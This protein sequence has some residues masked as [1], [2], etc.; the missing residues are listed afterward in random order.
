MR[1]FMMGLLILTLSINSFA[2]DWTQNAEL[3]GNEK[4]FDSHGHLVCLK[5]GNRKNIF[6]LDKQEL[7]EM[8][9][10]GSAHALNYPVAATELKIPV[11][12]ME[13]FFNADDRSPLRRFIFR[14]AKN[15]SP[16]KSFEDLFNWV[17]LHQYP[18][19]AREYGPN[20]IA[21]M[22]DLEKYPMGVSLFN[23]A[24]SESMTFS[25]AAC[26]SNNLF[27]TK[28]LGLTNRFPR[29]N[30]FFIIG[31]KVLRA[32]NALLFKTL[33]NPSKQDLENYKIARKAIKYV[34]L[35]KPLTL[36]LDT[37]LAQVGL[38]LALRNKDEQ[39]TRPRR[40]HNKAHP[41]KTNPADSKPAVWWNVKYKTKWLSDAS[42]D[43][44]NPIHTN[45]L[46]N[47]IGRGIDLQ[48]LD[49]WLANN[50]KKVQELTS[51]VFNTEAP[52]FNDYFPN[53]IDITRAKKGEKL[54]LKNCKGC[55][56]IYEKAWH[57]ESLSYQEQLATTKVWYHKKTIHVDVGTD[58]YRYLG[59]NSFYKDLNRL[60][61]SQNLGTVVSPKKGY[62]PPPLVGIWARWPYLHN[63][64]IPTLYDLLSAENN[65]PKFYIAT[66]SEDKQLDFDLEKNGYPRPE[67]IKEPYQSD[68]RYR[69]NTKIKGLSNRGHNKMLINEDG[70]EK[71]SHQD[72]LDLIHFLRSL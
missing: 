2:V 42:I 10:R 28:V 68:K 49:S 30:E 21:N 37:S 7:K 39:A 59:M 56:G 18:Q 13:K 34:D 70:S 33:V 46:W 23:H 44:G 71:F 48:R 25:C 72:K 64:S 24:G 8:I 54:F 53:R 57:D 65:R 69:F 9:T 26:H 43:S 63:N 38:S 6:G 20:L 45:F 14:I 55:H 32:S 29:A 58:P 17:G 5:D 15:I 27:G 12:A 36:G 67:Y 52:L 19:T 66:P 50:K 51:Y 35:K 22:G 61:I 3:P 41:L 1:K 62:V 60:K 31:K 4:C 40:P 16:F 11:S 47:E